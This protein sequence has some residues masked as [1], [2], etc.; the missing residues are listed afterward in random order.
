M[1]K[2]VEAAKSLLSDIE[3]MVL[4]KKGPSHPAAPAPLDTQACPECGAPCVPM[5]HLDLSPGFRYV[6][7]AHRGA[8]EPSDEAALAAYLAMV[9]TSHPDK[10]P[11]DKA[12]WDRSVKEMF[13][14]MLRAAYQVDALGGI[15]P[16][17][18]PHRKCKSF[19]GKH[20]IYPAGHEG[21]CAY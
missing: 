10:N 20:C 1:N 14:K 5:T 12:A 11:E 18:A 13:K 16:A 8:P 4:H 15:E 17:P 6:G 2:L 19:R 9:G 3:D 21:D 7:S